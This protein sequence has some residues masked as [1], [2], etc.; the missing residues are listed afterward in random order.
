MKIVFLDAKT[1]GDDISLR[2]F[3]GFGEIEVYQTTLPNEV[4]DRI[5][6]A[7]VIVTNKV[8]ID[9]SVMINAKRLKCICVAATGMNNID[10]DAAKELNIDVKNVK[11][12]ST[13]SVIQHTFAML[14]YLL[15]QLRYYDDYVKSLK[16]SESSL[17]TSLDRKFWEINGKNWGIIGLGTIGKGVAKIA[18]AFGAN[19]FY[20]STSKKNKNSN[21]PHLDL[22][23]LLQKSHIISIHAPLTKETENLITKR[24]L[25]LMKDRAIL[26]NLGRGKIINEEDLAQVIDK[27]EIYVG[28]DVLEKE[29]PSKD[30]PLL[31]IKYKDRLLITPHIA[32]TSKEAREKLIEGICNN[33]KEFLEKR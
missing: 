8:V 24:E 18:L 13:N 15:E 5:K 28:L 22:D 3:K 17:F 31:H 32:W 7:D 9:K 23:E 33:I 10:L 1:L 4:V 26:L 20:Y 25:E 27:K 21:Y 14:F 19:I 29:P 2:C 6:D 30:N 16:W 12:Y 11:A